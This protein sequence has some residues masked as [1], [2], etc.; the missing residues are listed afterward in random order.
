MITS[1]HKSSLSIINDNFHS[2]IYK[3]ENSKIFNLSIFIIIKDFLIN[4]FIPITKFVYKFDSL[5]LDDWL[6]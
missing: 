3:L 4:N 5:E 1:L 2:K 6:L